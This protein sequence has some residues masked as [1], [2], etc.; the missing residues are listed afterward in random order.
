LFSAIVTTEE[1][2]A[3]TGDGA[4]LQAMLDAEAALARAEAAAGLISVEVADA[5]TGCC[6]A[7]RFDAAELGRAA[8][9]GGNPVIPL[10]EGLVALVPEPC[11][12]WVHFGATSQ[13]I[14]DTAAVLI[15]RR[16]ADLVLRHLDGLGAACAGLAE[17]H[18]ATIM[19][20]RTLMQPALP[21]TFGFKAAAWLVTVTDCHTE[22]AS[23][24]RRLP[25]QLGGAV[26]TLAALGDRGPAVADSFARQ[27]DLPAPVMPWFANRERSA[28]FAGALVV[29]AGMAA[30]IAGDIALLMQPEVGEAAEPPAPGRGG[31]STLPHKRN[32]V[33][34]AAV[35][36]AARRASALGSV[37]WGALAGEH[38]RSVSAWPAEWQSLSELIV[39]AGGA[40]ARTAETVA[41]MEIDAGAMAANV[42]R[43]GGLLVAERV[44]LALSSHLGRAAARDAVASAGR[45]AVDATAGA[46]ARAL[47]EDSA[48]AAVVGSRG[49]EQLLDPA[50][51]LGSA[52]HFIDRALAYHR[53]RGG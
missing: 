44:S 5:I 45:R 19:T 31:S 43:F 3:A 8:R 15:A 50:G 11:R 4:W 23:A 18:R 34:A 25:A 26:G 41:G 36:A 22:L 29:A 2:S 49:L 33:G 47:L 7:E 1:L 32:P 13:D 42:E 9:G 10:V 46:L 30:K 35:G 21:I 51:Y 53:S 12:Q 37:F 38:E 28:R 39:L 14:L 17:R 16:A 52:D 20:G 24:A 27:L 6:R 48:V 40:V